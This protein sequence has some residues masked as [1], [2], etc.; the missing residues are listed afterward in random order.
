MYRIFLLFFLCPYILLSCSKN[1]QS[2][3]EKIVIDIGTIEKDTTS[4]YYVELI[5]EQKDKYIIHAT[6]AEFYFRI[7]SDKKK[8]FDSRPCD[9][10]IIGNKYQFDVRD[11]KNKNIRSLYSTKL[12]DMGEC[13]FIGNAEFLCGYSKKSD[14]QYSQ[15]INLQG[16]CLFY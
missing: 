14:T 12:G 1:P 2:I 6:R 7:I 10:I 3:I 9:S 15:V 5:E 16:L 8:T 13:G 4:I 11:F